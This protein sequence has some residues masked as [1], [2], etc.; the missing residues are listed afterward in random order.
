MDIRI[1][2]PKR[3]MLGWEVNIRIIEGEYGMFHVKCYNPRNGLYI[4]DCNTT[5]KESIFD[6]LCNVLKDLYK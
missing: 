2:Q 5:S 6:F 4:I 3:P 1:Q